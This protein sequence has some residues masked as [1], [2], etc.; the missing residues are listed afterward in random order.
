MLPPLFIKL[1]NAMDSVPS[2]EA[3]TEGKSLFRK[4][5]EEVMEF[6]NKVLGINED[7]TME[8]TE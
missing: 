8:E 2:N 7:F 4:L 6:Y 3:K 5:V 1:L